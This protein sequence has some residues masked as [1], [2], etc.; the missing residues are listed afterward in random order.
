MGRTLQ[1]I[2]FERMPKSFVTVIM[3][4]HSAVLWLTMFQMA[5][6]CLQNMKGRQCTLSARMTLRVWLVITPHRS[7]PLHKQKAGP[8]ANAECAPRKE[9][10]MTLVGTARTVPASLPSA[11]Q[12]VSWDTTLSLCIGWIDLLLSIT[13]IS[14]TALCG[15]NNLWWQHLILLV[16]IKIHLIFG[17]MNLVWCIDVPLGSAGLGI[18]DTF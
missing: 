13:F 16:L 10:D 8:T 9:S 7:Y 15:W 4:K 11:L 5:V 17:M 12:T 14:R 2:S 3:A 6:C 1:F 18:I